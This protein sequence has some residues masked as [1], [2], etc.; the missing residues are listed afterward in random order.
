MLTVIIPRTDVRFAFTGPLV[1]NLPHKWSKNVFMFEE[2]M[3]TVYGVQHLSFYITMLVKRRWNE[4]MVAM[5]ELTI[6]TTMQ[7]CI[8]LGTKV[9]TQRKVYFDNISVQ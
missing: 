3:K 9:V 5:H 4:K 6:E 7:I 1:Y 8:F 2:A